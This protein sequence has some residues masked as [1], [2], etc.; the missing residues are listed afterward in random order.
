M[1][2]ANISADAFAALIPNM[3]PRDQGFAASLLASYR[4]RKGLSDKQAQWVN[5]LS[6]RVLNPQPRKAE[7]EGLNLAP[8]AAL[9]RTAKDKG[10][11]A[12]KVRLSYGASTY[13]LSLAA[14]HSKNPG[15]LY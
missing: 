1:T 14:D 11:K 4:G 13:A 9:L 6:D 8:L 12:P 5:T 15:H 3:A 7:A 10:L 2:F